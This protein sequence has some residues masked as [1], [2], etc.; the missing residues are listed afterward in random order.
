M[1][2]IRLHG[3]GGQGVVTMTDALALACFYGGWQVQAFPYFGPERTGAPVTGFIRLD[4]Q[5]IKLKQQIYSPDLIIVLDEALLLKTIDLA[6]GAKTH[7]R[8]LIN[9]A[10]DAAAVSAA[11]KLPVKAISLCQPP[12]DLGKA[13][14]MFILGQAAKKYNLAGLADCVRAV[15]AKLADKEQKIIAANLAA[16]T[17]GYEQATVA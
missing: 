17:T 3:L 5:P 2:E 4:R 13:V 15:K 12:A 7:S 1:Y 14:N 11:T 6:A 10:R 8:L 16:L 9:T